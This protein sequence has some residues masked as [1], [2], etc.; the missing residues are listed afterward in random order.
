VV[1]PTEQGLVL[2]DAQGV[3]RD[4][5]VE[6]N[7]ADDAARAVVESLGADA[8]PASWLIS[9][10]AV[11]AAFQLGRLLGASGRAV[12]L[13]SS[14][15]VTV[16]ASVAIEAAT[17]PEAQVV[18][19]AQGAIEVPAANEAPAAP[20]TPAAPEAP[21]LPAPLSERA[22]RHLEVVAAREAE[23]PSPVKITPRRSMRV[24]DLDPSTTWRIY[25]DET[26]EFRSGGRLGRVV[27]IVVGER[28]VLREL[29]NNWHS[30]ERLNADLDR[31]L[32]GLLESQQVGIFG[33]TEAAGSQNI[34]DPWEA[35]VLETLAWTLRNLPR[36]GHGAP[37]VDVQ[38]ESRAFQGYDAANEREWFFMLQ[39]LQ[40][41]LPPMCLSVRVAKKWEQ[42]RLHPYADVVAH[43]WNAGSYEAKQRLHASG[44]LNDCLI[45]GDA[46][47]FKAGWVELN[48][49]GR[50]AARTWR[51][52]LRD[53]GAD[54]AP[55]RRL[56]LTCRGDV[57]L[58]RSYLQASVEHMQSKAV[59]L[60]RLGREIGWLMEFAPAEAGPLPRQLELVWL[61][62]RVE[63]A[64][65]RGQVDSG[66]EARLSELAASL[67]DEVPQLVCQADL[68][69][70]VRATNR[71]DFEGASARL[72]RWAS[73]PAAI[74]GL[75]WWGRT[76]SASGQIAAFMGDF[77]LAEIFF[78]D[79]LNAFSLLSDAVE[80]ERESQQTRAYRAIACMDDPNATLE[81]VRERVGEVASLGIAELRA[82]SA[83]A[84][85]ERQYAHHVVV[86]YLV[87]HGTPAEKS[88]YLA[89]RHRWSNGPKRD[90]HPWQ[91]ISAYRACL[92]AAQGAAVPAD[93]WSAALQIAF[94]ADQGPTVAFI[95][96]VLESAARLGGY[97]PS[98]D[99]SAI[100]TR[101]REQLPAAPWEKLEQA[102][103]TCRDPFGLM[104][105]VL[106]F[107]FR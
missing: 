36:A 92:L 15:H 76:Q 52:T 97:S 46:R 25:I 82:L 1:E 85:V 102:I 84:T 20:E 66:D 50:L 68:D 21:V 99:S 54:F 69:L 55:L 95:G 90:H 38:I 107:N 8:A 60:G 86:R 91:L 26:G 30:S 93:Q 14:L 9:T 63:A 56:G 100:T 62:A 32:Q 80:G 40:R 98:E 81:Q 77:E 2:T 42:D 79:A 64:N 101:T 105:A 71:F 17:A 39:A 78:R 43:T 3:R 31:A 37:Q 75:Q 94:G 58:W 70:A 67:F 24:P 83:D 22:L 51:D 5:F 16:E 88:A 89:Q 10:P 96:C 4:V 35:T 6:A 41:D 73:V 34:G 106:P 7:G 45:N 23:P 27:A 11:A 59:H 72:A 104:K 19:E 87:A 12:T 28:A 65:H 29:P 49:T 47:V 57:A 53:L 18:T 33:L 61:T 13:E 74:P 44:L 103:Q 48:Q